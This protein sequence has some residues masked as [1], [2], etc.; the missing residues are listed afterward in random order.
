MMGCNG[1]VEVITDFPKLKLLTQHTVRGCLT[2]EME[3]AHD[4]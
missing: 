1:L 4:N 3:S 2:S